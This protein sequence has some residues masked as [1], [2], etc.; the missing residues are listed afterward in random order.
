MFDILQHNGR[1]DSPA[2]KTVSIWH[3]AGGDMTG[4]D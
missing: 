2:C 1:K 3:A 4:D